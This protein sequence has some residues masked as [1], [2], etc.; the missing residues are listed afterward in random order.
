MI[1]FF[2]ALSIVFPIQ[3]IVS[4]L[5]QGLGVG[6]ASIVSR[7]LGE[8]REDEAAKTIGTTY[9]AVSAVPRLMK[10]AGGGIA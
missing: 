7:K 9:A 2:A 3:M 6:A 5:A 10:Y 4:A 1:F 8:R